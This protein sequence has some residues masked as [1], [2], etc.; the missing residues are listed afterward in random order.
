MGSI[1]NQRIYAAG[2]YS[3][4]GILLSLAIVNPVIAAWTP[5]TPGVF[6]TDFAVAPSNPS[7]LY[8]S[9]VLTN[10]GTYKSTNSGTAWTPQELSF[11]FDGVAVKPDDEKTA[12]AGRRSGQVYVTANGG[13]GWTPTSGGGSHETWHID[14]SVSAPATVY[15]GGFTSSI[16]NDGVLQKSTNS[17]NNWASL[18]IAMDSTPAIRSVAVAPTDPDIVFVGA[19]PLGATAGLYRSIDGGTSFTHLSNLLVSQVDAVAVDPTNESV[20]YAASSTI[21][22]IHR[23]IDGGDSW[24]VIHDPFAAGGVGGFL[25][26]AD[27]AIDPQNNRI[28][29]AVGGS[30]ST[31]VIVSTNCGSTWTNVDSTGISGLPNRVGIDT[32]NNFVFVSGIGMGTMYRNPL[33]TLSTGS[34]PFGAGGGSNSNSSSSSSGSGSGSVD[35]MLLSLLIGTTIFRGLLQFRRRNKY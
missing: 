13:I 34:C 3:L 18:S 32:V 17:G 35:Y 30:G 19:E 22:R 27:I 11:G 2:K 4:A 31:N 28:I 20:V 7:T 33:T 5:V 21:G 15:A 24:T 26:V 16:P 6:V 29:Y 23:S 25:S 9:V 1:R 10:K 8:A 14:Y 12:L